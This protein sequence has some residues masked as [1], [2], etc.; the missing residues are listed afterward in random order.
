M[1]S[2]RLSFAKRE[3]S[4]VGISWLAR[5]WTGNI[6]RLILRVEYNARHT[7]RDR[8]LLCDVSQAGDAAY[9]PANHGAAAMRASGY[10][11]ETRTT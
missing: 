11:S 1:A 3:A 10:R 4:R 2:G 8:L 6:E 9:L 7:S 5:N